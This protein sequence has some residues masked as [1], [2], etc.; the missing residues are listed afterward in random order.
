[1]RPVGAFTVSVLLLVIFFTGSFAQTLTPQEII[2]R[3]LASIGSRE[4]RDSIKTLMAV[5]IS[6][7][8]AKVPLVKGGGKAI[9]VSDP[10]NLFFVMSLNSKEYPFEKVGYF[11]DKV[12]LPYMPAGGRSLLGGFLAENTKILTNGLF[13]G[14][15][16]LR[17]PLLGL[18]KKKFRLES[19]GVK[20]VDGRKMYVL[21]F[22]PSGVA[23]TQLMMRLYFDSETFSHVRT[24]FVRAIDAGNV[25]FRQAN[26]Q[27]TSILTLTEE[28]SDFK[29][30]DGLN[31]PHSYRVTFRANSNAAMYENVW[32]INVRQYYFNQKLAPD[33]FTFETK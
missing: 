2:D 17:W 26:Q 9:M 22:D 8:E 12:N 1:M 14:V 28:F 24:E 15:M 31:L 32:G 33:F 16:S 19:L 18:D 5:G 11:G 10:N 21:D 30:E 25:T 7:F 29:D 23:S 6:E 20:K 13:S 4:K 3:H 27:G